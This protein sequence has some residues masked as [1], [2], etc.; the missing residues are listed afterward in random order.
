MI[1]KKIYRIGVVFLTIVSLSGLTSCND[2]LDVKPKTEEEAASL[3]ATLDGFKSAL[4]GCYIGL[5]QPELYGRELTYGMVGVLGQEWGKGAT[6]DNSYTAYSYLQNYNYEQSASK[7]LIDQAWNKMYESVANV[8]TLIEYTELKKEVLGDYYAVVRGE[9]LAMRAYIHFDLLRLFA[10][11]DF[12]S[13]AKPAIPYVKEARPAIAPQL[14]P[15]KFVEYALEDVNAAIALLKEDPILTGKDITGMDNG[16]LANRN[17]H[18]NYYAAVGLKARICLYAGNT[19]DAYDAADEVILAQQNS[20]LF[21]WVKTEDITTT[22]IELRDRTFSTEHLFAFNTNKLGEYIKG[23]FRETSTPL[24]SRI[25][26]AELYEPDDYRNALYEIYSGSANVLTKFWQLESVYVSGQ[27]LVRPKRDRMP[28][29]RIAEMYYIATEALK[30]S[31]IGEA[32]TTL[33]MLR[34]YRGLPGLSNLSKEE[35]QKEL[36]MEYYRELIG[37]G[38]VFFYHKRINTKMIATANAAYVLPMPDD[39]IDL[40]QRQ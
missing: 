22:T 9:A 7:V 21:P 38:Q 18:L 34:A 19:K 8:N 36:E 26:P 29:I 16:Y 35:L 37:E 23:Y 1:K 31:N 40:G 15:A 32:I 5:C 25:L 30:D 27:G 14:T 3:F 17:F 4:A 39:E 12:S 20:D 33:N 6:L 24:I 10:P 2:W 11:Y 13:E 28:G